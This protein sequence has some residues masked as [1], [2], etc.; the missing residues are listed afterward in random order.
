MPLPALR[1]IIRQS[2]SAS[3]AANASAAVAPATNRAIAGAEDEALQ[4][5]VAADQLQAAL[6]QQMPV[7]EAGRRVEQVDPGEVALA[8]PC[9]RDAT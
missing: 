9:R 3:A 4:P 5:A 8:A 2:G 7:V 6:R 1:L